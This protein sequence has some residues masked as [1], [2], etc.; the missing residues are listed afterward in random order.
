MRV[1]VSPLTLVP[2]RGAHLCVRSRAEEKENDYPYEKLAMTSILPHFFMTAKLI[3][4][5]LFHFFGSCCHCRFL[6][7]CWLT[8]SFFLA[9]YPPPPPPSLPQTYHA[10]CCLCGRCRPCDGHR[11][12]GMTRRFE[13]AQVVSTGGCL[14]FCQ[15][16]LFSPP[17]TPDIQTHTLTQNTLTHTQAWPEFIDKLKQVRG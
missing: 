6:F 12:A 9:R 5:C 1:N 14:L 15:L 8:T 2:F 11:G 3:S 16:P 7:V 4:N 17:H 13:R 10:F